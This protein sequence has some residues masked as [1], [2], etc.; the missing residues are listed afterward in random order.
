MD[1][2]KIPPGSYCYRVYP[3]KGG[4]K[5][6]TNL[7]EFGRELR[8]YSYCHNHKQVLCPYW[9]RTIYGT[10]TCLFTGDEVIDELSPDEDSLSLLAAKIGKNAAINFPKDDDLTDEIKICGINQDKEDP[11]KYDNES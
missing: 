3:L 2:S 9:Q 7:A 8:E 11:W 5:L 10:V 1:A 6:P 4:E